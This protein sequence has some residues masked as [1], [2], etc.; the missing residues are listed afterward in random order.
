ML[1]LAR[2][3]FE[4]PPAPG[5]PP[6]PR[7]DGEML[8]VGEHGADGHQ[9]I[10]D[11]LLRALDHRRR[12]L[13][14]TDFSPASETAWHLALG[15]AARRRA[16]VDLVH[17]LDGFHE[18]FVGHSERAEQEPDRLLREITAALSARIDVALRWGIPSLGH[19]RVGSPALEI[20]AQ[21]QRS[22]PAFVLFGISG[23]LRGP[24]G[25]T[26]GARTIR[27]LV[28]AHPQES[29]RLQAVELESPLLVAASA[30]GG[31]ERH[32]VAIWQ[33]G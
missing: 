16:F 23:Q 18:L 24:F 5:G 27:H 30:R 13:V 7:S 19:S 28:H 3:M 25:S 6:A 15:L 14:A 17:V 20:A 4:T 26:W 2:Q 1:T 22:R 32:A 10:E 12:I 31:R 8:A 21:V 33:C 9:R 11:Q 29:A